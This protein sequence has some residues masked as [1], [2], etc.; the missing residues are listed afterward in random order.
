MTEW[1]TL[2]LTC[3]QPGSWGSWIN[4]NSY[5]TRGEFQERLSGT[6]AAVR[7]DRKRSVCPC[8][9]QKGGWADPFG[10]GWKEA[11]VICPASGPPEVLWAGIT[12]SDLLL[13]LEPQKS[14]LVCGLFTYCSELLSAHECGYTFFV[15]LHFLWGLLPEKTFVQ[16]QEL[17]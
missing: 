3:F 1:L 8:S 7:R 13:L 17:Q 2:T 6:L 5:E 12:G 9:S 15:Q 10:Y 14:S 11:E 4:R 16:V